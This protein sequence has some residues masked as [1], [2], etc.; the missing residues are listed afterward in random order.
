MVHGLLKV[1]TVIFIRQLHDYCRK[2]LGPFFILILHSIRI[3]Y[4][5]VP[6]KR[7]WALK[8]NSRFRPAWAL[9]RD[10]HVNSICL[11]GSC[12]SDSLKFGIWALTYIVGNYRRVQFSWM[13]DLYHFV[14]LIFADTCTHAHYILYN[15]ASLIFTVR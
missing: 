3:Y 10:I 5:S 6:G 8:Y 15:F 11:Y 13:I 9:S 2:K 14:G 4:R 1:I 12:N 7:P